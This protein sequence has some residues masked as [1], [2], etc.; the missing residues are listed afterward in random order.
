MTE[1]KTKTQTKYK[2]TVKQRRKIIYM[3]LR[4]YPDMQAKAL[5]RPGKPCLKESLIR[6]T[7]APPALHVQ[8]V[9]LPLGE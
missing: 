2:T 4:Y 7:L 5:P 3:S 9:Q 6:L 1:N 8:P